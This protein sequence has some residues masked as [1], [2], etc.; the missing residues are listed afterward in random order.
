MEDSNNTMD[1]INLTYT[2]G[3]TVDYSSG[4]AMEA[5][6]SSGMVPDAAAAAAPDAYA[7]KGG[8]EPAEAGG[9]ENLPPGRDVK[10]EA[11]AE[12]AAKASAEPMNTEEDCPIPG[13]KN[14]VVDR[15]SP[16]P[17]PS[18]SGTPPP[19]RPKEESVL[20]TKRDNTPSFTKAKS[21]EQYKS[22]ICSWLVVT[23]EPR[24]K[25]VIWP[26]QQSVGNSFSPVKLLQD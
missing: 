20:L 14:L 9:G 2:G 17:G 22:E 8:E 19:V 6:Q 7:G 10:F 16:E 15:R 1:P 26:P 5:G 11:P 23:E 13:G 24:E 4:R 3:S 12:T 21:Y 18:T 25:Q